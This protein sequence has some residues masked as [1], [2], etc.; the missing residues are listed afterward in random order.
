MVLK[1]EFKKKFSGLKLEENE[2]TLFN[3]LFAINTENVN[4]E[5]KMETIEL[6][7]II[8]LKT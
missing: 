2:M 7:Y 1:N 3:F 6:L 5:L 8:I 4:E